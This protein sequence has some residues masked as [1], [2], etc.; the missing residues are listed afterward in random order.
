M[1][2]NFAPKF[3]RCFAVMF[4]AFFLT[5][6]VY[7]EPFQTII[8]NGSPTNR[9]DIAILG[10]GYTAAQLGKYQTDVQSFIQSVFAQDPYREYQRY[11]NVHRIDVTSNQSGADHS[12]R[13][14]PVFVDTALDAAYNC[15]GIQRLICV[16]TNK[17]NQVIARTLQASYFDIVLVIV[18]DTEYGG[19][20]GSVAVASVDPSAVELILHEVGHSFG[21]LADEYTGGGPSCNPNVEPFEANATR[22]TNRAQI[23]WNTWIAGSTPIPTTGP[24]SALPG[25]YLGSKYCDTGLYRPTY[26]SKMNALGQPFEQINTEQLVKRIYNF[27]SPINSGFPLNSAFSFPSTQSQVF[28]VTTLVPFTHNLNVSWMVDGQLR[29]T[30]PSFTAAAGSLTPGDHTVQAMVTDPTAFVRNDPQQL[31]TQNRFWNV[32]VLGGQPP[33]SDF[34]GDGRS[35]VAVWRE[36]N[37]IWFATTS[38]GAPFNPFQFGQPSDKIVPGDYDGDRR[39]DMAVFRA[40]GG[41]WYLQG[42]TNGFS[43]TQWGVSTDLPVQADFDGDGKTDIAVWRPSSGIWFIRNSTTGQ[44]T[45]TQYGQDGDRPVAGDFDGD[46]KADIAVWRPASGIWFIRRSSGGETAFQ[47]GSPTDK[48]VPADYDGDGK[49]D[50]AVYRDGPQAL[51]YIQQSTAGFAV[52]QWGTTNDIPVQGDFD[53]DGKA[54]LAVWRPSNG[55]WFEQRSTSGFFAVQYGQLGDK[56]VPAS[57]IPMQ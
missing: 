5:G 42:S 10:D 21:F 47:F 30:G 16:D 36:A 6:A 9:I 45:A 14:P 33:V 12:N 44:T 54:D 53:G 28:A 51:W 17:V 20:G 7:A 41:L 34:D 31:L 26:N 43:V 55:I 3:V 15:S 32:N 25:L 4:V 49:T 18:N 11:F 38:A 8:N 23:K 13:T 50:I 56:P 52:V 1:K 46:G 40:S 48:V 57:Y 39:A 29:G 2:D 27:V 37:G 35:D 22:E 24:S 19:S